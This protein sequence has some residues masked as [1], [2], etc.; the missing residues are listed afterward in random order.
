MAFVD[1]EL[2]SLAEI[3]ENADSEYELEDLEY[4]DGVLN[5]TLKDRRQYVINR[6]TPSRQIWLYSPISGAGHFSYTA[7]KRWIDS[8]KR[9]LMDVLKKELKL[10][11]NL[12]LPI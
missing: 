10:A 7:Q 5:I 8:D 9:D 3:I 6:H 1:E 4:Q 11:A 12:E 2:S